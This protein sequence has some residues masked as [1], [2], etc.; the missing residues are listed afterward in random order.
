LNKH[1]LMLVSAAAIALS[2][3]PAMADNCPGG[4]GTCDDITTT[5]SAPVDTATAPNHNIFV[6]VNGQVK[7]K[8]AGAAVTLNSQVPTAPVGNWIEIGAGGIVSN[9]DTSSAVGLEVD[10]TTQAINSSVASALGAPIG[11]SSL[12][13]IDLT[14]SGSSKTGILITGG[15]GYTGPVTLDAGSVV[16]ITGDN[17]TGVALALGTAMT[18]TGA[19]TANTNSCSDLTLAGTMTMT[20]SSNGSTSA[21]GLRLVDIAGTLNGDLNVSAG[22]ALEAFGQGAQGIVVSGSVCNLA[23]CTAATPSGTD[24]GAIVN[25]GNIIIS[26]QTLSA[27]Q[28]APKSGPEGGSALAIGGNVQGGIINDGPTSPGV[29]ATAAVL[30]SS[31][32]LQ[33]ATAT[34]TVLIGPVAGTLGS[35]TI[36][37]NTIDSDS[38]NNITAGGTGY[39]FINRGTITASPLGLAV[40]SEA[41]RVEGG[42]EALP[43]TL[44]GALFNAGTISALATSD[45][46]T[47][48]LDA[49]GID[50]QNGVSIPKI[51][52]SDESTQ[53]IG[54]GGFISAI[55]EG[56]GA[57]AAT[58]I[59]IGASSTTIPVSVPEIDIFP[60]AEIRASASTTSLTTVT[61]LEAIGIEDESGSLVR[62]ENAGT[63]IATATLL[64]QSDGSIPSSNFA[65]AIDL[66]AGTNAVTVDN[67]GAIFGDVRLNSSSASGTTVLNV[68]VG[69]AVGGDLEQTSDNASA[70]TRILDA[71]TSPGNSNSVNASLVGN[72]S[73]G[74]DSSVLNVNDFGFVNGAVTSN[75]QTLGTLDVN[76]SQN[77]SLVLENVKTGLVVNDLNV[78]PGAALFT[79][80]GASLPGLGISVS[81]DLRSANIPTIRATGTVTIGT[82]A[83]LQFPIVTY[84]PQGSQT[85]QLILAP[86]GQLNIA[87]ADIATYQAA[88]T[89]N[90]PFFFNSG[91]IALDTSQSTTDALELTLNPKTAQQLGL[92]GDAATMFPVVSK[93]LT[94][95]ALDNVTLDDALGAAVV[96]GLTAHNAESVFSQFAPDVSG[97]ERAI[98]VSLTDSSTGPV[99]ARQRML[100]MYGKQD[101]DFT[102]WGQEYAQY[103][104]NKGNT[105]GGGTTDSKD[106]GFGFVLGADS[107]DPKDGW[108]GGSFTFF[109]GDGNETLP[110]DARNQSLWYM[111][112][113]YSEWRGH[114]LFLDTQFSLAGADLRGKRFLVITPNGVTL[115]KE[116]SAC[117]GL[118]NT[119]TCRE[120]DDKRVGLV[121]A[122]GGTTGAIFNWNNV[123]LMPEISLDGMT[124]R[125]EGYTE[126]GGGNGFNLTVDPYYASSLRTF[127]GADSRIDLDLGDFLLQPEARLGYRFEFLNDPV[128]LRAAFAEQPADT[129]FT[130]TGPDPGRGNVVAGATLGASTDTWS[131]GLNFDYV[132][133]DNGST[134]E[135]GTFS[136]LG[137]I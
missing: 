80:Q 116:F 30:S 51:I 136:L 4:S 34:P 42:G 99:A 61:T 41:F 92:T 9:T 87:P 109:A 43:T 117:T 79:S 69:T 26:G 7:V 11:V 22:S 123:F 88:L 121:G 24:I 107:G 12:G 132:R 96:T 55:V 36:G 66:S 59:F 52:L 124:M 105:A 104:T 90:L 56:S 15:N 137:R 110:R 74:A 84:V 32:S 19:C 5:L 127:I 85:F 91:S 28:T 47:T 67:V 48:S 60:R 100:R 63:I 46:S 133:G 102:L 57:G 95:P 27:G 65:R 53:T 106:H 83:A 89:N 134:T 70:V 129:A 82:G 128:K 10:T 118:P 76:V 113:A 17:G 38:V 25:Q 68:G 23:G 111:L 62:I 3:A 98:A 77:G 78:A 126:Q 54:S 73:F 31:G 49:S 120:A 2:A 14:G 122:I 81:N 13:T 115:P 71:T 130:I 112:T 40:S 97:D 108:Y 93:A 39:S 6:D 18:G 16:T 44:T 20:P 50:I 45:T 131:M 72:I 94:L 8:T 135:V 101:G 21:S 103:F 29:G 37:V 35:I 125:E 1:L 58:G 64:P 33:G 75:A 114:H 119:V 86:K